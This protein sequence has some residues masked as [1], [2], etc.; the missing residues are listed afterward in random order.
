M[1]RLDEARCS[2]IITQRFADLA[3]ASLQDRIADVEAGPDDIE[4]FILRDELVR[5]LRQVAQHAERLGPERD[6]ALVAVQALV[7]RVET[8]RREDDRSLVSHGALTKLAPT[9]RHSVMTDGALTFYRRGW[10]PTDDWT[11]NIG[12]EPG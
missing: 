2:G 3:D 12:G 10:E 5:A 1:R 7:R 11:R 6:D 4:K 8:K 9:S